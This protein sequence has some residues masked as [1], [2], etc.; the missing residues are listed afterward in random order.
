MLRIYPSSLTPDEDGMSPHVSLD[1]P[2]LLL[3]LNSDL[4][5]LI[6]LSARKTR[7]SHSPFRHL[8]I[9]VGVLLYVVLVVLEEFFLVLSLGIANS[10]SATRPLLQ[11]ESL[12]GIS[13]YVTIGYCDL[14]DL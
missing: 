13:D 3:T 4:A 14:L 1:I 12:Q 6:F 5:E 11:N 8:R 2:L 7:I 9:V 10:F